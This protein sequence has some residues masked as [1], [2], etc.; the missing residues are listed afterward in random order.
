MGARRCCVH[1]GTDQISYLFHSCPRPSN[2]DQWL[3]LF[4]LQSIAGGKTTLRTDPAPEA[5]HQRR[6]SAQA[7]RDQ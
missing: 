2:K 4:A 7:A 5:I 1:G 3:I 6:F